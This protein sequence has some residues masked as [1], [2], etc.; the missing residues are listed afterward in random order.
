MGLTRESTGAAGARHP[1]GGHHAACLWEIGVSDWVRVEDE[2]W[3]IRRRR[4]RGV[5][6]LHTRKSE[7]WRREC[8]SDAWLL[9]EHGVCA[10][11]AFGGV[12]GGDGVDDGLGFLMADFLCTHNMSAFIFAVVVTAAGFGLPLGLKGSLL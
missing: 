9:A 8:L 5:G 1:E 7:R 6:G 12:G 2:D 4:V 10:C 3:G 11:L